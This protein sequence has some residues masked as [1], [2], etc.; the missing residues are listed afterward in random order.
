MVPAATLP[1][2]TFFVP[3]L[4]PFT[5][6]RP[7]LTGPLAVAAYWVAE[8]G[9]TAGIPLIGFAMTALLVSRYGIPPVRRA[10]EAAVIAATLAAFLGGGAYLNEH[11][12][13]PIFAVHR[14][15]IVE[16]AETPP[17]SPAL[18]M[19]AEAFYALPT[20]AARSEHLNEVL[21][22]DVPL[23]EHVRGHWIAETGYSFPSGHSY[24]AMMFATFF[25]AM[26]LSYCSGRRLWVF[27]LL[28][29]WAVAVCLSRPILRVHS[30]TDIC[31]GGLE[32]MAVGA[33]TFLLVRGILAILFPGAAESQERVGVETS[34]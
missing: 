25:L 27:Y 15:N 30:P 14:P 26:G 20:K 7:D 9:G 21:T 8:S 6:P 34:N 24:S 2:L 12:V 31:V 23:H 10:V 19:S 1:A 3:G 13:K 33:L 29:V 22:D 5:R 18:K 4:N 11:V 28:A 17:E 32:G 16:L